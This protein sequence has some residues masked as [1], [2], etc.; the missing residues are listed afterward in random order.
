MG[1]VFPDRIRT[2]SEKRDQ[3]RQ[4][5]LRTS[6]LVALAGVSGGLLA[7]CGGGSSVMVPGSGAKNALAPTSFDRLFK[8]KSRLTVSEAVG[9]RTSVIQPICTTDTCGGDGGGDVGG[10]GG[11]YFKATASDGSWTS[12]NLTTDTTVAVDSSSTQM[13]NLID[14]AGDEPGRLQRAVHVHVL[15]R[16]IDDA[17]RRDRRF[18]FRHALGPERPDVVAQRGLHRLPGHD[19]LQRSS[20]RIG[21]RH[22]RRCELL[23]E[24]PHLARLQQADEGRNRASRIGI[25]R[26]GCF[27]ARDRARSG[28]RGRRRDRCRP[29][30]VLEFC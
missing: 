23:R 26:S 24:D 13:A 21:H 8:Y 16:R 22:D 18:R 14:H 25:R 11:T 20:E 2:N 28:G 12:A 19:Q 9:H 3:S 7:A 29:G 4:A 30:R 17:H 10:S 1:V 6:G 5:F 15:E 27:P